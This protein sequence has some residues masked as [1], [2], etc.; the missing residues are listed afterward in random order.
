MQIA[1]LQLIEQGKLKEET[2]VSEYFPQ[3]ANAIVL[4]NIMSPNSS[5][6]PAQNIIRVKHLLNFTSG[7][8]YSMISET[9]IKMPDAYGGIHDLKDPHSDFLSLLQVGYHLYNSF[10]KKSDSFCV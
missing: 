5:S 6:K 2:P 3:F 10:L 4:D 9:G 7:L 1:A 8:F